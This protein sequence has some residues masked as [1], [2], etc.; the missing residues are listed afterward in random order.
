MKEVEFSLTDLASGDTALRVGEITGAALFI[1]GSVAEAGEDFLI[2]ARLIRIEKAVVLAADSVKVPKEELIAE[3][4][5]YQYRFVQP[6]GLGLF[7]DGGMDWAVLGIDWKNRLQHTP[8]LIRF[9]TGVSY[10][11]LRWIQISAGF[12]TGWTEFQFGQFDP[13]APDYQNSPRV[14]Y[15]YT[16]P[17]ATMSFPSYSFEYSQNYADLR[18]LFVW[19]PFQRLTLSLGGGGLLGM[20]NH[21]IKLSNLPVPLVYEPPLGD[22]TGVAELWAFKDVIM[23]SGNGLLY[24]FLVALKAEY[25]LSP[26]ILLFLNGVFRMT[27]AG[28]PYR[29]TF[30]GL[31]TGTDGYFFELSKWEP[32]LT[33]YGDSLMFNLGTLGASLGIS[34]S[35]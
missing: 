34:F 11:L 25:Y 9:T 18:I 33:P 32:N 7:A 5:S 19:N 8:G 14:S 35:F 16:L 23:E 15:Y 24:G 28:D 30:G 26:R 2:S 3:A 12:N 27:F 10:R 13:A 31:T 21:Y 17:G 29:Y 20:W 6:Q 1:A 4:R 22:P